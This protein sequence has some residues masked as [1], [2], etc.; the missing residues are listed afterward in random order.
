[1]PFTISHIAAVLPL[2]NSHKFSATALVFGSVI[3]DFEFLLQLRETN[4]ISHDLEGLL[5]FNLPLGLILCF[6]FHFLLK[7]QFTSD[8]PIK[9]TG[10]FLSKN[11]KNWYRYFIQNKTKVVLSLT[12]GIASHLLV[13]HVTHQNG[14]F[15]AIFPD[16]LKTFDPLNIPFYQVLQVALSISGLVYLVFHFDNKLQGGRNITKH[17]FWKNLAYATILIFCLRLFFF[18]EYNTFWSVFIAFIG[19][20]FYAWILTSIIH[21]FYSFKTLKP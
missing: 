12:I 20:S 2:T 14:F 9:K 3:P 10:D 17:P 13:D 15:V 6:L 5:L 11:H 8:L 4:G 16:L 18:P 19:S 1:M 21:Q 7:T